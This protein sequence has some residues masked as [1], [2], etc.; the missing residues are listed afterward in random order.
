MKK[1]IQSLTLFTALLILLSAVACTS[2]DTVK[3]GDMEILRVNRGVQQ[4]PV[5]SWPA[6]KCAGKVERFNQYVDVISALKQQRW[7]V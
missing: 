5:T 7:T 3:I 1:L 6:P 2:P 4:R